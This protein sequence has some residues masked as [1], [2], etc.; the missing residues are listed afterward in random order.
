MSDNKYNIELNY[1][2]LRTDNPQIITDDLGNMSIHVTYIGKPNEPNVI[3]SSNTIPQ[4]FQAEKLYVYGKIHDQSIHLPKELNLDYDGELII[5]NK[6]NTSQHVIYTVFLLKTNNTAWSSIHNLYHSNTHNEYINELL[7]NPTKSSYLEITTTP[8]KYIVYSDKSTNQIVIIDTKIINVSEDL[9]R[10]SKIQTMFRFTPQYDIVD[11]INYV[12]GFSLDVSGTL[13]NNGSDGDYLICDNL[14][15]GS[16]EE[17]N[18][19]I[20]QSSGVVNPITEKNFMNSIMNYVVCFVLFTMVFLFS[21]Y[22]YD[23]IFTAD[24]TFYWWSGEFYDFY[25]IGKKSMLAFWVTLFIFIL[26]IIFIT[27]GP[28]QNIPILTSAGIGLAVSYMVSVLAITNNTI[29]QKKIDTRL[30]K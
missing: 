26:F 15:I 13:M 30:S 4:N 11:P 9:S 20:P 5:K 7:Q 19:I 28:T 6:S 17:L 16:T 29:L 27:V 25:G 14:P 3:Y 12:E 24:T 21:S 2:K 10:Y 23:Y 22:F 18:Y 1:P 8:S